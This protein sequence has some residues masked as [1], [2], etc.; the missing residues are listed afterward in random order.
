M[1]GIAGFIFSHESAAQAPETDARLRKMV[2]ALTHRGP[3]A[4][5]FFTE[6][7]AAL[8]H[9][10]L[11]IIDLTGGIQPMHTQDRSVAITFNG[12]I[13][14][15]QELRAELQKFG[16]TFKTN[17]DTE[18]LLNGYLQWGEAVLERLNGMF[19]FAIWDTR[20]QTVFAARDRLG[21][22]PLYWYFDPDIGLIFASELT[23]LLECGMIDFKLSQPAL[24]R[25]LAL[26]YI[27]G[28]DAAIEG[29]KRLQPG[30]ALN[31]RVGE[32][33][34][35]LRQYWDLAAIWDNNQARSQSLPPARQQEEFDSLLENSLQLRML[36]DVPVG[37]FLSG[38]VDSSV[39][40]ALMQKHSTHDVST[41]TIGFND[42]SFDETAYARQTAEFL[43][44]NHHEQIADENALDLLLQVV[45][46]LDEPF[47]DTSIIPTYLLCRLARK[48]MTVALTG[49]GADELLAGYPTHQA[50]K[51]YRTINHIPGV[52]VRSLR[53]LLEMLPDS[54]QKVNTL[55]KAKQFLRAYPHDSCNAHTSWRMVM[56][57]AIQTQLN[58]NGTLDSIYADFRR[59]HDAP[60]TVSPLNRFLYVDYKTWLADDILVKADRA[61]MSHGLEVRSPFLDHRLVE[62]SACLSDDLKLQGGK[63]KI[64]LRQHAK[65]YYPNKILQRKKTGFNSPVSNWLVRDWRELAEQHFA[66]AAAAQAG[67]LDGNTIAEIWQ[68]HL[69]GKHDHGYFLFSY[70]IMAMWISKNSSRF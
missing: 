2:A 5:G 60:Q 31:W 30:H 61:S 35:R 54:R 1:C 25:Y 4:D 29:V 8:G 11:R 15:F 12:E 69:R 47:A 64:A 68:E 32:Q 48:H 10:R 24:H 21:Q 41:F 17:S 28:E 51:Y 26:S 62:Y 22:K 52:F 38:G 70:L 34:P 19:A 46:S 50:D 59:H 42:Q 6:G 36:A 66:P 37:G 56:P 49:D 16:H 57:Q 65:K 43:G 63:N 67:L 14:N 44:L 3:D 55:F 40:V 13:Y 45:D 39:V 27:L 18:V 7:R 20:T 23:A 58:A 33:T 9:R 53:A